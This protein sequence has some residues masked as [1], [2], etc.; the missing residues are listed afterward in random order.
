MFTY[1]LYKRSLKPKHASKNVSELAKAIFLSFNT[2]P[3]PQKTMTSIGALSLQIPV[4][5]STLIGLDLP[6]TPLVGITR[7]RKKILTYT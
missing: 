5:R 6:L 7:K 4:R 2:F 1:Y 3:L